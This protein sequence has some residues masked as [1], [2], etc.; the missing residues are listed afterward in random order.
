MGLTN[1]KKLN[2]YYHIED[3]KVQNPVVTIGIFDGVHQGHQHILKKLNEIAMVKKSEHLV[4]TFWPHPQLVFQKGKE[5]KLLTT[6]EE[7]LELLEKQRVKN[8]LFI[9]FSKEFAG[10]SYA[11][12]VEEILLGKLQMSS[13][14]IGFN[15]QFGHNKEGNYERLSALAVEH[16]FDLIQLDALGAAETRISSTQI[17]HMLEA[18]NVKAANHLLGYPYFIKG[19]IIE[20]KQMGRKIGFPTANLA[21]EDDVKLIP[22]DGVYAVFVEVANHLYKGMLNLGWRPTLNHN[23]MVKTVEVHIIDFEKQIYGQKINLIFVDRI[24]NEKKFH[25]L[26]ELKKQLQLDKV[27]ILN[28]LENSKMIR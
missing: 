6:R 22:S 28:R 3:V 1:W 20:G 21:I 13:L 15:Q 8:V 24:R 10:V 25:S 5:M 2:V 9:P 11:G 14:V 12:F 16:S 19:K 27:E 26:E 17:R 7:K 18:G 4:I 23:E